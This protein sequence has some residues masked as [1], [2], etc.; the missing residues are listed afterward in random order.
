MGQ[1]LHESFQFNV[2]IELTYT[3]VLMW[4]V[5]KKY[6]PRALQHWAL[7]TERNT[8]GKE[9]C[10]QPITCRFFLYLIVHLFSPFTCR[11]LSTRMFRTWDSNLAKKHSAILFIVVFYFPSPWLRKPPNLNL[12]D[13]SLF[14]II[15]NLWFSNYHHLILSSVHNLFGPRAK[16]VN[17]CNEIFSPTSQHLA[18]FIR[19]F[20]PWIRY[21]ETG[22]S[23]SYNKFHDFC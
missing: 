15:E 2:T 16:E 6:T 7:A 18:R 19:H 22:K 8:L 12:K 4:W 13:S 10:W 9:E 20:L 11:T 23:W 3:A 17:S 21:L 14:F 1:L 5:F